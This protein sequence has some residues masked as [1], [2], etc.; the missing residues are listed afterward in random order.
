MPMGPALARVPALEPSA[1]NGNRP[2]ASSSN[3]RPRLQTSDLTEYWAPFIRSGAMYV[4]VPTKVFAIELM[5]S[6]DTPKSH[7]LICPRE[8]TR[9]LDGFMSR[10][11]I[12]CSL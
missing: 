1:S 4:E 2:M 5:S 10:C 12:L 8:L 6:P 7:S 9:M 11:R 3:D